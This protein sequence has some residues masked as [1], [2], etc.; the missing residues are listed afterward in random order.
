MS[1]TDSLMPAPDF[2]LFSAHETHLLQDKNGQRPDT[3]SV[4]S[5]ARA[6]LRDARSIVREDG[7]GDNASRVR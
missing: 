1:P 5:E 2:P 7:V 3:M 6:L 4:N